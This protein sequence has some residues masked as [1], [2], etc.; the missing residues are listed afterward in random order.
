MNIR[1]VGWTHHTAPLAVREGL[2]FSPAQTVE[3]LTRWHDE[4]ASVEMVLLSTCNRVEL[5]AAA[6]EAPPP[7]ADLCIEFLVRRRGLTS[8]E[9]AGSV[10]HR[11]GIDALRHLFSVAA[12]LDSM[13]IGEPQILNQVKQAYQTAVAQTTAG[14]TLHAAFQAALQAARRVASETALHQHRVSIPSLAVADFAQQIFERF[15]D[16]HT[17]VLGAGEMAEETLRYLRESGARHITV[18]NRSI[19]RA[20]SLAAKFGGRAIG[21]DQLIEALATADLV[22]SAVSAEQ[23]MIDAE[24]FAQVERARQPGALFILDLGMPRNFDPAI[25]AQPDVFLYSIDDL[26]AACERNRQQRDRELPAARRIVEEEVE[27]FAAQWRHR[28]AHPLIA[29]LRADW[30]KPKEEEL[31]RLLHKL[32][33]LDAKAEEEIRRSFDRLINK[34]LHPPLESLRDEAHRGN[35][36]TLLDALAR[37]FRLKD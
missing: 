5:Y 30:Q 17:V 28:A 36:Q 3:A 16:K 18:V 33:P 15:D 4:F 19:D 9:A 2:S 34:L 20:E 14:P 32:P 27:R 1:M 29:R 25:G 7:T 8:V 21:W 35:Y 23:T 10:E 13:V 12:S 24:R 11:V 6:E 22:V 37:L 31:Q 26:K